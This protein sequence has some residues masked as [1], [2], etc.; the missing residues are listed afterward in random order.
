MSQEADTRLCNSFIKS[1]SFTIRMFDY[2]S[3]II[4]SSNSAIKCRIPLQ[5]CFYC[6]FHILFCL[7]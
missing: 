2:I 1:K 7:Q 6:C 4:Y 3:E 5:H